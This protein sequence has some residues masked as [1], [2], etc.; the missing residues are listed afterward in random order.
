MGSEMCIR[1][2][3]YSVKSDMDVYRHSGETVKEDPRRTPEYQQQVVDGLGLTTEAKPHLS[4]QDLYAVIEMVKRKAA[5]FWIE[6]TPRTTV[7]YFQHDTIP[8]GPP[9]RLPPHNLKG[10][11]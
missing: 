2:R 7:R 6:G 10:A 8:T 3:W 1:D 5:A 9:C 11:S 4:Q